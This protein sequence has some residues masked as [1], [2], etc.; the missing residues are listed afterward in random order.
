MK[1]Q[2]IGCY[3]A[4]PE[5]G[6]PTS[7]YL[8]TT[9]QASV[10]IDCGSGIALKLPEYLPLHALDALVITHYHR[11]HC[12]DLECFQYAAMIETFTGKRTK[13]MSIYGPQGGVAL[14]YK[15]YCKGITYYEQDKWQIEDLTFEV[16]LN[17]HDIT[18]YAIKVTHEGKSIVLTGDTGYY[19][20]LINFCEGVELLIAESSFYAY[21]KGCMVGHMCSVEAG[22]LAQ[23]ARVKQLVLTHFPHYGVLSQLVEEAHSIYKGKILLASVGLSIV[24]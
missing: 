22:T 7:G 23:Q 2:V 24:I 13:E 19:E 18:S 3:G 1:L 12:A 9:D 10:L 17:V 21:Q 5:A 4:Y 16:S 15:E 11:D 8:I 14:G 6:I 20:E